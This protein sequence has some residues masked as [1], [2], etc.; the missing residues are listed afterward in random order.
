[1]VG[2]YDNKTLEAVEKLVEIYYD[3]DVVP[4]FGIPVGN[5][6]IAAT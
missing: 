3:P 2:E 5:I 4:R 1:M 6:R